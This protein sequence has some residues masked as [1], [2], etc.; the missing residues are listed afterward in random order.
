M[1]TFV[2][3]SYKW[4]QSLKVF[5]SFSWSFLWD[6]AQI[7]TFSG[8]VLAYGRS[9]NDHYSNEQAR[10]HRLSQWYWIVLLSEIR[11]VLTWNGRVEFNCYIHIFYLSA[12]YISF[13]WFCSVYQNQNPEPGVARAAIPHLGR[14]TERGEEE[15]AC[16][17]PDVSTF[18]SSHNLPKRSG[19]ISI[20]IPKL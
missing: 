4:I 17:V 9:N 15:C 19:E 5:V 2:T 20:L 1:Q 16:L 3:N 6:W 14:C 8:P 13:M 11:C 10:Q 18:L 7:L 12:D